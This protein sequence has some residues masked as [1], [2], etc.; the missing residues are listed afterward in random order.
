MASLYLSST[1]ADLK[2]YRDAIARVL[3][4]AGHQV[5]AMEDYVATGR[6]PPLHKCL[7]DVMG[8]DYYVGIFAWRYGYIPDEGNPERRSITELEYCRACE[9]DRPCFIFLLEP[10]APWLPQFM[11]SHTGDGEKGARIQALRSQL[12][13]DKLASFFSAPNDL[14]S[15]VVAAVSNW[16]Q[17]HAAKA[18]PLD[19]IEQFVSWGNCPYQGLSA[20]RQE[21]ASV[22]FGRDRFVTDLLVAVQ[23]KP[24]V[25]VVGASGSGKSSLVFAGLIPYLEQG[26]CWLI[27]S[28]RPEKHPFYGLAGALVRLL[29]PQ[30]S[31]SDRLAKAIN[32]AATI[33]K[34]GF[35]TVASEILKD[36]PGKQLLLVVDQFE[37]LFTLCEQ[38]ERECFIDGLLAAIQAV[39]K[40][41]LV[42]TLRADFCG[43]AYADRPLADALQNADLKLAPMNR[44]E[45]RTA[46]TRPAEQLNVRLE[47]GLTD[48]I[49]DE[50]DQEPGSLPLLEFALTQ[51]WEQQ[52]N[53]ILTHRAYSDIG[54]VKQALAQHADRVFES[55]TP[56][57]Q[58]QA[59]RI[60]VQ[61]VNPGE[62]TE[63]T[64]RVA[65]RAEV[66]NWELV[67]GLA[68]Q[69]LVVT[70]LNDAGEETVEVVHEALI[71][72][73][74]K[75]RGWTN[76][77]RKFRLWQEDLRS[78][79]RQWQ[80][81]GCD[82]EALLRG[83]ALVEAKQW[84]QEHKTGLAE[85]ERQFI[86]QSQIAHQASRIRAVVLAIG[87]PLLL[88]VTISFLGMQ[89]DQQGK[90][91]RILNLNPNIPD[92]ASK[93]LLP[94]ANTLLAEAKAL[95]NK[96]VEQALHYHQR[97]LTLAL[98]LKEQEENTQD[99]EI[100]CAKPPKDQIEKTFCEAENSLVE[101]IRKTRLVQ[102][103]NE[104]SKKPR[105]QIGE[106]KESAM[107]MFE[108][109]FSPG[110]LQTTYKI[111]RRGFGANADLNDTG[112]IDNPGEVNRMP[113]KIIQEIDQLWRKYTKCGWFDEKNSQSPNCKVFQF[114]KQ[115]S[116]FRNVFREY[117]YTGPV[118][119]RIKTCLARKN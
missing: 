39:P 61:L 9:T 58:K 104:L 67:T 30:E 106:I 35:V 55:L 64:R 7:A 78:R 100:N 102:L 11:D 115:Q 22:F 43:Q 113:C 77:N 6:Y 75:L 45:L 52:E 15:L 54:G 1:Y 53:G 13:T 69:R 83:L 97:I 16:E 27:Q 72:E 109:Q 47:E 34:H 89:T 74:Q 65:T 79:L 96:D 68:D 70:G 99:I 119:D 71:R 86:Q 93:E 111:L 20:F 112:S 114:S 91:E 36:N 108:N 107:K 80:R 76:E 49:L 60:L 17:T 57:Q 85:E 59:Q 101:L 48:R 33:K 92:S 2:D 56:E 66:E 21:H 63:D 118:E 25:A 10:S 14:A 103:E 98:T 44:E 116:L 105:P 51:L 28:F 82:R 18:S 29:E 32:L 5:V 87:T 3:R 4:K 84:L 24:L 110:A 31:K 23:H 95:E 41:K 81:M 40:L 26:Q 62:K 12:G 90:R 38:S 88:G 50:V 19:E 117:T 42:L 46:I 73:W 94:T 37:E 8:C